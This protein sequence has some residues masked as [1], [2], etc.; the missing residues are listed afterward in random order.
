MMTIFLTHGLTALVDDADYNL[1]NS[2]R[3]YAHTNKTS[4]LTYARRSKSAITIHGQLLGKPPA[5]QVIDFVDG[6]TLNCQREN[7]RFAT[8]KQDAYNRSKKVDGC[9]SEYRGV[10][11]QNRA[12]K[13]R[14]QIRINGKVTHIGFF[15]DELDA[16]LAYDEAGMKRDPLFF[17]P[18]FIQ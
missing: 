11:W 14:A 18:N 10:S 8:R 7:I 2:Y 16:A 4:K 17:T 13:W 9:S 12:N 15:D 5:G 3:W 6:N 1:I